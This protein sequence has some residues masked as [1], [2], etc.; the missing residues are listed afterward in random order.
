MKKKI[1]ILV[2]VLVFIL[3]LGTIYYYKIYMSDRNIMLR[4]LEGKKYTCVGDNCTNNDKKVKYNYDLKTDDLYISKDKYV[5]VIGKNYPVLKFK[6]GNKVC[7]YEI[8]DYKIGDHITENYSY[9]KSCQEYIEEINM[10]IDEYKMIVND[11]K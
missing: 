10:Y 11:N 5:L 4:Y 6:N 9:E 7:N 3:V 8:D 2:S 1:T